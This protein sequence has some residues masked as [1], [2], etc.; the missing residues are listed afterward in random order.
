MVEVPNH[1]LYPLYHF[2]F[3]LM[4]VSGGRS[5]YVLV[6]VA[7]FSVINFAFKLS[8]KINNRIQNR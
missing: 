8:E 7:V 4:V 3:G 5:S 2:K 6:C 1:I